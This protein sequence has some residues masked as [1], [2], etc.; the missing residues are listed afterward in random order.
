[1]RSPL[2]IL[3]LLVLLLLS[4]VPGP[5]ARAELPP[6]FTQ[7]FVTAG[8]VR[9]TA[10]H[11]LPDGRLL[12]CEQ[13]GRLRI[14]E[15]GQLLPQPALSL[16]VNGGGERGLVG[17]A[18][19]PD[20]EENGWVYLYYTHPT[21]PRNR[22]SRFTMV[23]DA[24]SP[25]SERVL[26]TMERLGPSFNH[27]GGGLRF[28]PDGMLYA[29]V[30]ENDRS[31]RARS[32]KYFQ[33]KLLRMAPDGSVPPDNPFRNRARKKKRLIWAIGLRNP[34][35]FDF[36]PGTGRLLIN[37]PGEDTWEE[38]NEGGPGGN[39]GWPS[40]EGPTDNPR[41]RTPVH[42][43]R[44]DENPGVCAITGAAFY[45]PAEPHYPASFEGAY[46]FADFCGGWI[47][48]LDPAGQ[49][50]SF[51]EGL[52]LPVDLEVGPDGLLYCLERGFLDG[53]LL[54]FRYESPQ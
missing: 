9:P 8:L 27:N 43:Y 14:I 19:H 4:A 45:R 7:E 6:G 32:L 3:V 5:P 23:G 39:Y 31:A 53:R 44:H 40:T 28:G 26:L 1:M 12:V 38:I 51:A 22:I 24:I 30:G 48:Y 35:T 52:E 2:P 47:R 37:D 50:H 49:A 16:S 20:F 54:R 42:A 11:F 15:D 21:G 17:V 33:G 46:F 41:F 13:E 34:Y 18:P 29:G 25:Q 36:D 10:M